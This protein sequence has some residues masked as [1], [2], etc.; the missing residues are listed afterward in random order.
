MKL[1][2]CAILAVLFTVALAQA[3]ILPPTGSPPVA[4]DVFST[5]TSGPFLANTGVQTF[6]ATNSLGKTTIL[7]EYDA[8]VYKDPDNTFCAGCLDF[9]VFVESSAS[10]TDAIERITLA[11]FG[12]FQTDV[13]Y[14]TGKGGPS[15]GPSTVDPSTVD[16]SSNGSVVGFNFAEPTG[17]PPGSETAVL[18]IQTNATAFTAG[19]LQIIDSS[20]GSVDAFAPS[21]VV[22]EASSISLTLL[23]GALLG[24][25][26]MGRRRRTAS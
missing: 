7:G 26:F 2:G 8:T 17:V 24:I 21:C 18:E 16:R 22:P 5:P 3:A 13:G 4:P 6:T 15:V 14:S 19:T 25:G 20:V 10:S 11:S 9:F 23:G 1:R 12:S